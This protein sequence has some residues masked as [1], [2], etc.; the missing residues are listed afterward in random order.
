ME[1]RYCN[2]YQMITKESI[3]AA[4]DALQDEAISLLSQLVKL[5][6]TLGNEANLKIQTF[7]HSIYENMGLK[8]FFLF[9]FYSLFIHF[10]FNFLLYHY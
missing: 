8:V 4:V 9:I 10:L 1:E 7:V 3:E 2:Q 5:D 6:S